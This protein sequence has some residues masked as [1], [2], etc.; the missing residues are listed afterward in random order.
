MPLTQ[1]QLSPVDLLQPAPSQSG[2]SPTTPTGGLCRDGNPPKA[3]PV[4]LHWR[5]ALVQ[6][7][8]PPQQ[9]GSYLWRPALPTST[10]AAVR[11][12]P[13]NKPAWG[14]THPTAHL[15]ELEDHHNRRVRAPHMGESSGAPGSGDQ[16]GL[17][18]WVPQ[19]TFYIRP[20]LQDE[21]T[22]LI[23]LFKKKTQHAKS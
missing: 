12:K 22:Q 17:F 5:V 14:P 21:E 18:I 4:P 16:G 2:P 6:I 10:I 13:Y 15:Q 23:Y 20:L 11:A 9:S 1:P 7:A 3:D 19:E 8:T